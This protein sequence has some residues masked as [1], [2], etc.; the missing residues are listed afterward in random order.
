MRIF[1]ILQTSIALRFTDDKEADGGKAFG[2]AF[3]EDPDDSSIMRMRLVPPDDDGNAVE[4]KF[5]RN[6]RERSQ[7]LWPLRY[8]AWSTKTP[9]ELDKELAAAAEKRRVI[10]E[11]LSAEAVAADAAVDPEGEKPDD[12]KPAKGKGKAR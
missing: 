1:S 4:I 3:G 8:P 5:D 9:D 12:A 6:G 11:Q 2:I 7:R 10:D